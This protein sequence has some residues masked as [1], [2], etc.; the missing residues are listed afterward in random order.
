M[1]GTPRAHAL[2]PAAYRAR[3]HTRHPLPSWEPAPPRTPAAARHPACPPRTVCAGLRTPCCAR[4]AM[5]PACACRRG[6]RGSGPRFASHEESPRP[7]RART[8]RPRDLA[9]ARTRPPPWPSSVCLQAPPAA[10]GNAYPLL[11]LPA[12]AGRKRQ[13]RV[14]RWAATVALPAL[15]LVAALSAA[16]VPS[17]APARITLCA[18]R[19]STWSPARA[20]RFERLQAC[21]RRAETLSWT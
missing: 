7:Q 20:A 14:R 21:A 1:P 13:S 5:R 11:P 2:P 9:R 16:Q 17:L 19:I 10:R 18:P 4:R 15:L 12:G 3:A 8:P 6:R